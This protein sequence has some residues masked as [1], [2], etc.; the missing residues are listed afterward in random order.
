[1]LSQITERIPQEILMA[2][3]DPDH[4]LAA[5]VDQHQ[6]LRNMLMTCRAAAVAVV[7]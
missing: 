1:M 3:V 6:E 2:V 4:V 7:V 5:Q